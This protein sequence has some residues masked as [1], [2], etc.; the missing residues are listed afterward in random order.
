[1]RHCEP[2]GLHERSNGSGG[3]PFANGRDDSSGDQDKLSTTIG[4]SGSG[5]GICHEFLQV[6]RSPVVTLPSGR[7]GP[8]LLTIFQLPPQ[9]ENLPRLI[10]PALAEPLS[11]RASLCASKQPRQDT[12]EFG[13]GLDLLDTAFLG[14]QNVPEKPKPRSTFW[15]E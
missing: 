1:M 8:L 3:Q 14:P 9:R 4:V 7:A 5:G 13:M 15:S 12:F 11:L 10:L 6:G 2:P